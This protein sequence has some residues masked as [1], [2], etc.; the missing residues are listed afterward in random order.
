MAV[1]S[2]GK[3]YRRGKMNRVSIP[4]LKLSKPL[5]LVVTG[6]STIR[7]NFLGVGF[8]V[9]FLISFFSY[10]YDLFS[11]CQYSF[12]ILQTFIYLFSFLS[13]DQSLQLHRNVDLTLL[14]E[15]CSVP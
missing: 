7:V 3:I 2:S 14:V 4:A 12:S 11:F 6:S 8:I 15:Y 5:T 1:E 10:I 13:L 9:F